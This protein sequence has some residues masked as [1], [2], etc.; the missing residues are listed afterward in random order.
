MST[1][2]AFQKTE[3]SLICCVPVTTCVC[4]VRIDFFY[5]ECGEHIMS[6]K[7]EVVESHAWSR[8]TK[9][10]CFWPR[11]SHANTNTHNAEIEWMVTSQRQSKWKQGKTFNFQTRTSA[12]KKKPNKI[13]EISATCT[14]KYY[15][16]DEGRRK[17]CRQIL[18][19]I[20]LSDGVSPPHSIWQ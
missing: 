13:N 10:S 3:M 15:T 2:L 20:Q 7:M 14:H 11:V 12:K 9:H 5:L 6:C 1:H 19:K 8:L 18:H 4:V 17:S 16:D